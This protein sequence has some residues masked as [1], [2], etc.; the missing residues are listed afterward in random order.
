MEQ[1]ELKC[2]PN[3][4]PKKSKKTDNYILRNTNVMLVAGGKNKSGNIVND[5]SLYPFTPHL[6]QC[7]P[8]LPVALRWGALGLLGSSLL[9]CGGEGHNEHP[10]SSCWT[11]DNTSAETAKWRHHGVMK[12]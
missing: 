7:L 1:Q 10:T 9:L 2:L 6:S 5:V 12:R 11:I 4:N 8:A 3:A